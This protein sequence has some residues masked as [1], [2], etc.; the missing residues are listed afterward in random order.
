MKPVF[1]WRDL[2]G[3]IKITN[4]INFSFEKQLVVFGNGNG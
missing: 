3:W 4:T 2:K 1:Y